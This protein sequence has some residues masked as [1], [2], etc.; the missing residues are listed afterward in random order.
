MNTFLHLAKAP[1][2]WYLAGAM[3]GFIVPAVLL[4]DNKTFGISSN[5][6]HICAAC[7]PNKIPFFDYNWKKEL[8]NCMASTLREVGLDSEFWMLNDDGEFCV[9]DDRLTF[10]HL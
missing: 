8:W 2:P 7:F 6:R 3:I 9:Y 5:L 1:W 4:L 10:Y